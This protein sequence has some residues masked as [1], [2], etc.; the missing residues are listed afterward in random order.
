MQSVRR[1]Y[2]LANSLPTL[3][4]PLLRQCC[5]YSHGEAAVKPYSAIPGPKSW[6]IIG[7]SLEMN[8]NRH[9][10]NKYF[11]EGF[12]IYGDIFKIDA[13]GKKII[14]VYKPHH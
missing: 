11:S 9:Q 6:P 14:A 1:S 12:K 5:A 8:A 4:L 10:L 3:S 2:L 13:F 7:N